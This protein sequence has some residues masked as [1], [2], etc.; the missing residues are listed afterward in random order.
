MKQTQKLT[1]LILLY[2][3]VMKAGPA[4]ANTRIVGDA[5]SIQPC[6]CKP[7]TL[8]RD[9]GLDEPY[10]LRMLD[11]VLKEPSAK[12][13]E[14]YI[15]KMISFLEEDNPDKKAAATS[16]FIL[17]EMVATEAIDLLIRRL[18]V[19]YMGSIKDIPYRM[20]DPPEALI[21]IGEP[22]LQPLVNAVRTYQAPST[23]VVIAS[24]MYQILRGKDKVL[25]YLNNLENSVT[26]GQQEEIKIL[27]E[28]VNELN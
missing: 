20:A 17:G 13:R 7:S 15:K 24:I 22:A 10:R 28:K 18:E 27:I 19:S 5:I 12:K 8:I 6:R 21:R 4:W 9:L 2:L 16:V 14:Q 11:C 25:S 3:F 1:G 26:H 23:R